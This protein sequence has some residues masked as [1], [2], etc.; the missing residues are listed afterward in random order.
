MSHE[1]TVFKGHAFTY[2]TVAGDLAVRPDVRSLLDLD[3]CSDPRAV[4]DF[5]A[6]QVDETVGLDVLAELHIANYAA[7]V[8]LVFH[9][10]RMSS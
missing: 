10:L 7:E 6:V 2:E 4:A 8:V 9:I 3:E 1:N 5:T